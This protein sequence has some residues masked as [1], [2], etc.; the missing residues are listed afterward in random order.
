M[1]VPPATVKRLTGP[2]CKKARSRDISSV[3]FSQSCK[4]QRFDD[5][6]LDRHRLIAKKRPVDDLKLDAKR[7]R[8]NVGRTERPT[9]ATGGVGAT[10]E[11]SLTGPDAFEYV[12]AN[13]APT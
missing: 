7:L 9:S 6:A 5:M 8:S 12:S 13:D 2:W 3:Q 10:A 4:R 1:S 11:V